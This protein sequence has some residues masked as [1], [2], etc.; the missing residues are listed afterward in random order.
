[1]VVAAGLVPD[2]STRDTLVKSAY[3]FLSFGPTDSSSWYD[4]YQVDTGKHAIS[5]KRAVRRWR[6]LSPYERPPCR[7]HKRN[8]WSKR[9]YYR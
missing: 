3:L 4:L 2:T 8:E 9:K 1:M 5:G 7:N 6:V